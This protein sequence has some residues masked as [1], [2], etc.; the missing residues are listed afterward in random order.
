MKRNLVTGLGL[1]LLT[2]VQLLG[3]AT[4]GDAEECLPGDIECADGADGADGKADAFDYK[5]DPARMSQRLTY[6]LAD[7]PKKGRLKTPVWK[8]QYPAAA[9]A[10]NAK[11]AWADTYWPTAEGS[12]N[13]R[14]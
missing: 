8:A 2:S 7:L 10:P 9:A 5:N 3:C 4:E 1:T 12:H 14:W 11:V 6:K 13:H